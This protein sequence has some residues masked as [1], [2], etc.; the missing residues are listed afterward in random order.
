MVTLHT[1]LQRSSILRKKYKIH[2]SGHGAPPPL[3]SFEELSSRYGFCTRE[4]CI[5]SS[6]YILLYLSG[7]IVLDKFACTVCSI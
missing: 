3:E 1:H 7:I 2:V 4:Y 6:F 5:L